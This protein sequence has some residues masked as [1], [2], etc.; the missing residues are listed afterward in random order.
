MALRAEQP[1]AS[2]SPQKLM[3]FEALADTVP[4]QGRLL[5]E[6]LQT[7]R[8]GELLVPQAARG[9]RLEALLPLLRPQGSPAPTPGS[10]AGTRRHQNHH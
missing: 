8:K 9:T 3:E 1:S 4:L 5:L 2:V 6:V 10:G 7:H